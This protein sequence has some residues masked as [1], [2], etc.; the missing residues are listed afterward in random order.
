MSD[1]ERE[2]FLIQQIEE[3]KTLINKILDRE[4]T[5]ASRIVELERQFAIMDLQLNQ[6]NR[7][8]E[9]Q[10]DDL[11]NAVRTIKSGPADAL[12]TAGAIS[13]ALLSIVALLGLIFG[14]ILYL[15]SIGV[16]KG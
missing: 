2:Q 12:K 6:H 13:T 15:N 11:F 9:R 4:E 7:E 5:R 16:I 14:A 10:F 3:I 8:N 1:Q